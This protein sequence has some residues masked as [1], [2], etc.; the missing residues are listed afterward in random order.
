MLA[1][2]NK[3][4]ILVERIRQKALTLVFS[5]RHWQSCAF[6][7]SQLVNIQEAIQFSRE[8]VAHCWSCL[9]S[10]YLNIFLRFIFENV[11][12]ETLIMI[13]V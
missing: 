10:D 1:Q 6:L 9:L 13:F 7:Y 12:S 5:G 11:F 3:Y 2:K 8:M 4:A